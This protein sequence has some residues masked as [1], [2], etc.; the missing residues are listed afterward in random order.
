ETKLG[1]ASEELTPGYN[2]RTL[3]GKVSRYRLDPYLQLFDFPSPNLSAEKRFTTNVPL[4]RLFLMN[5]DFVQQ[6]SEL[7]ERRIEGEPD[8]AA[9]IRKAYSIVHWSESKEAEI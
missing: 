4:Q 2:R 1:G 7:L 6:Q 3:Y 8:M 9:A 5:S